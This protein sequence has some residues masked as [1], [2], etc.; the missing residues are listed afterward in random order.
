MD[1]KVWAEFEAIVGRIIQSLG[2]DVDLRSQ[3][4]RSAA[5]SVREIDI[6]A[7]NPNGVVLPIE[8]KL[9]V[10]ERVSLSQ[11]RD[12]SSQTASMKEVAMNA[13]PL[14]VYGAYIDSARRDW[15]EEEFRIEIWDRELLLQKAGLAYDELRGFFAN[16][17]EMRVQSSLSAQ[18]MTLAPTMRFALQEQELSDP[19]PQPPGDAL[20]N[21]L[22]AISSG[23]KDAKTYEA[24]CKDIIDYL[25]GDDLR[26]VRSQKRTADGLNIYDLIYRVSPKHPFWV[27]LTRDFRARVV[28]FECKNYG[29]PI[30]AMQVFTTERYLS[31]SA[32]RPVCFVLSRKPAHP[33]AVQAASGVMRESGKLLV[34]LSD[35]D[36]TKMLRAKDAQLKEGGTVED[37]QANDPT[38][39]LDQIIYDFVAGLAR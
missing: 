13:R 11:L 16:V 3:W 29:K 22:T 26:D 12:A 25:F 5:G 10:R 15:A 31:S 37:M 2:F 6:L 30:G 20:I 28:L 18:K 35:D 19:R 17:D 7:R 1:R 8:V 34:F 36:L 39:I 14:L 33:H 9:T 4:T 23:K 38:E 27:T 32:L 21:S 24:I